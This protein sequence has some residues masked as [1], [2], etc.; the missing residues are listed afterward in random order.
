[1]HPQALLKLHPHLR[2]CLGMTEYGWVLDHPLMRLMSFGP[3]M[4]EKANSDYVVLRKRLDE[5]VA[6]KD[7]DTFMFLHARP[8]RPATLASMAPQLSDHDY[9]RLLGAVYIDA[10]GVGAD[11]RLWRRLLTAKR[12]GR[13]CMMT[14]E[15]RQ[16]LASM[17]DPITVYRGYG[18]AASAMGWSWTTDRAKAEWFARRSGSKRPGVTTGE[19]DKVNVVA[20]LTQRK[21]S[22]IVAD[23]KCIHVLSKENI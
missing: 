11:K 13:E 21:E 17:P 23:P 9:W 3:E 16:T 10:E 18:N 8:H 20:Y 14:P 2:P 1:M 4:V 6:A 15:E 12:P 19:I 7:W 22:E 5:S